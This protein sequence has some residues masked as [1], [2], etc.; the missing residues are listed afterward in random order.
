MKHMYSEE[1]LLELARIEN[2]V[3]SK[4]RNRFIADNGTPANVSGMTIIS[5]KWTLNGNNLIF[6]ILGGINQNIPMNT[7]I[8]SFNLPA[9]ITEKIPQVASNTIDIRKYDVVSSDGGLSTTTL[10]IGKNSNSID[11]T[12]INGITTIAGEQVL[13]RFTFNA[14]IDN[15]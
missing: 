3:D 9:W 12:T 5:S 13:F 6:E 8:C 15:E 14:I 1:E 7:K 11:F 2:L 4:G 10:L